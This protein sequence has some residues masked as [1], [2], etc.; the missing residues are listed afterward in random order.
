MVPLLTEIL[1]SR[2]VS[3]SAL[4]TKPKISNSDYRQE[5]PFDLMYMYQNRRNCGRRIW[6]TTFSDFGPHTLDWLRLLN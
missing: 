2:C 5:I 1:Q 6:T 4:M 3:I